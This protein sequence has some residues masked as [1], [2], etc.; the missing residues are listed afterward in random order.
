M[1]FPYIPNEL[2]RI[3]LEFD[4]SLKLR[5]GKYMNQINKNDERYKMLLNISQVKTIFFGK[6]PFYFIRELGKY[7]VKLQI[8]KPH[9]SEYSYLFEKKREENNFSCMTIYIYEL[10]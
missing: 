6:N 1:K 7:S 3:I 10:I 2:V 4:G 5:N 9:F 8:N